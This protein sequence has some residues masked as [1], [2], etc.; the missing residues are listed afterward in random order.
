MNNKARLTHIILRVLPI[1]VIVHFFAVRLQASFFAF[2]GNQHEIEKS[3]LIVEGEFLDKNDSSWFVQFRIDSILRG[4]EE[5]ETISVFILDN[6]IGSH[7]NVE[8][9]RNY[10]LLLGCRQKIGVDTRQEFDRLPI[11]R[12]PLYFSTTF[13][14]HLIKG[15]F[16]SRAVKELIYALSLDEKEERKKQLMENLESGNDEM[17]RDAERALALELVAELDSIEDREERMRRYLEELMITESREFEIRAVHTLAEEK[18][19]GALSYF[20]KI[21][22]DIDYE[23][24]LFW[25]YAWALQHYDDQEVI[26]VFLTRFHEIEKCP[27]DEKQE[28]AFRLLM[29]A[30]R[31]RNNEDVAYAIIDMVP[32]IPV[33]QR[34]YKQV[35]AI[36]GILK[37][38]QDLIEQ[39]RSREHFK[40]A[41]SAYK[42]VALHYNPGKRDNYSGSIPELIQIFDY[43]DG[44]WVFPFLHELFNNV[45]PETKR[46]IQREIIRYFGRNEVV[47]AMPFLIGLL[48][49]EIYQY[50]AARALSH[51]GGDKVVNSLI[52]FVERQKRFQDSVII[53]NTIVPIP[54]KILANSL[55]GASEELKVKALGLIIDVAM[56]IDNDEYQRQS[57]MGA[58]KSSREP[59]A[60]EFLIRYLEKSNDP[61]EYKIMCAQLDKHDSDI[62]VPFLMRVISKGNDKGMKMY[63][64]R[65]LQRI[66]EKRVYDFIKDIAVKNLD[67]DIRSSAVSYILRKDDKDKIHIYLD[68]LRIAPIELFTT[69]HQYIREWYFSDKEVKGLYGK[70]LGI[71]KKRRKEM[72]DEQV[73]RFIQSLKYEVNPHAKPIFEFAR[74]DEN[75]YVREEAAFALEEIARKTK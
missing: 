9:N 70:L 23:N 20:I 54:V 37:N 28:R 17:K 26:Q 19:R 3:D 62:V 75:K 45:D 68:F 69:R 38:Y 65:S 41:A 24:T 36:M 21:F 74:E 49:N 66:Q 53:H 57:A 52:E 51:I 56:D 47:K 58:L 44:S 27:E 43:C 33:C 61:E 29:D 42:Q 55:E 25:K 7:F 14:A 4:T 32:Q 67:M 31:E 73:L 1:L 60:T 16:N 72:T 13:T 50:E 48:D 59:M 64:F 30:F 71:F 15:R 34:L 11:A 40:E 6:H 35:Q 12:F 22:K 46:S 2:S 63:A 8:L 10:L 18:Y 5:S 39:P